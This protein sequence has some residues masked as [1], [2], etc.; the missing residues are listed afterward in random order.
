MSY[1]VMSFRNSFFAVGGGGGGEGGGAGVDRNLTFG[2]S[3]LNVHL[4][5]KYD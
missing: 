3:H 2:P 4:T 1:D 5:I